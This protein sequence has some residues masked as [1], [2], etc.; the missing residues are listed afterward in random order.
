MDYYEKS[1]EHY[2]ISTMCM[3]AIINDLSVPRTFYSLCAMTETGSVL[4][5][6][7]SILMSLY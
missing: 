5:I 3:L 7:G 6:L 1:L 4:E 2:L